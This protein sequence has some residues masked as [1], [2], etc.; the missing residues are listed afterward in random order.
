[1][2]MLTQASRAAKKIVSA[3]TNILRKANGDR[4]VGEVWYC[5]GKP[6]GTPLLACGRITNFMA[7]PNFQSPD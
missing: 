4:S 3:L 1:M 6:I 2:K 7:P 5:E